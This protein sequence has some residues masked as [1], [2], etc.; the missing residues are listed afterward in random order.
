MNNAVKFLLQKAE[1]TKMI[2]WREGTAIHIRKSP[3]GVGITIWEN[4]NITRN[5]IDLSIARNMSFSEALK[6]MGLE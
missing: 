2:I 6:L 5:D 4:G 3:K 1:A